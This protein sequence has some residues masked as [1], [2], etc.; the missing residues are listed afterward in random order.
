VAH[1]VGLDEA[2]ASIPDG[3]ALGVGGIL[4]QR[5]PIALLRALATRGARDLRLYS[6]LA[7]LDVE[8]LAAHG[9]LAEAHT[10][11]VGF[12][13]LGFAPA[14]ERAV[15]AGSIGAH[16]YTEFLFVA[17]LRASL[18]GL[19]FLP[20]R[21]GLGSQ[22]LDELGYET[23]RCPYTDQ[24]LVAVPGMRPDVTVLHAEAADAAGTVLGPAGRDFLF[25]FDANIARAAERV[26]V[27]VERLVPTEELVAANDRTLLFAHEVELVVVVPGGAAPTSL[28]GSYGPDLS[29]LRTYLRE[30]EGG[31]D[32]ATAIEVLTAGGDRP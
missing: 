6:F 18:A 19:P 14:Y 17:G 4:L 1:V 24:E 15:A 25:D 9:V 13:Q 30:V 27:T 10:G 11:Y 31:A 5:K 3:A 12:E 29:A 2:V 32:P 22:V 7:S 23:I 8:L 28:P 21:G 20:A 26:I 16:E